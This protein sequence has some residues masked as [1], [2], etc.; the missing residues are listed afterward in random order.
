MSIATPPIA[1]HPSEP[2]GQR[3]VIYN[4]AWEAYRTISQVLTG[5]H[6]RLTY[7]R[8]TLEVMTISG[9]HGNCGWLLGRLIAV[10]S[11]EHELPI[12]GFSDM[13]CSREDLARGMEPDHCFYITSEPLVRQLADIDL[14]RDP[15]PD[16]GVEIDISRSSRARMGIYAALQVPE[17]WRYDGDALGVYRLNAA[18]EYDAVERSRYFPLVPPAELAAFLAR[19]TELDETSLVRLF[20]AWVRRL[21][22]QEEP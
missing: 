12:K 16:L 19:R 9:T 6:V 11:E 2:L 1:G 3:V 7:D 5:R 18:G 21:L 15:A 10:L 17:V 8:G 13:T 22:D 14:E 4:V 20:R